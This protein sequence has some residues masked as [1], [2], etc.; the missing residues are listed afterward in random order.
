MFN[1]KR[2]TASRELVCEQKKYYKKEIMAVAL[3]AIFI[4]LALAFFSYNPNDNTFFYYSS[5]QGAVTNWSGVIGANIAAF[6]LYLLGT[7]AYLFLATLLI[8][9]Y[10]MVAGIPFKNEWRRLLMLP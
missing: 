4:F 1:K 10:M 2:A 8:P 3:G 6:F 5:N 7:A 9:L